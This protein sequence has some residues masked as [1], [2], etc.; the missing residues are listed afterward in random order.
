MGENVVEL[1]LEFSGA[2][3]RGEQSRSEEIKM[4]FWDFLGLVMV[5]SAP[6]HLRTLLPESCAHCHVF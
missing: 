4:V 6:S 2:L 3:S 1:V 5:C